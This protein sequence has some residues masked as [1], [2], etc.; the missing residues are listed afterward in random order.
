MLLVVYKVPEERILQLSLYVV[1]LSCNVCSIVFALYFLVARESGVVAFL[2]EHGLDKLSVCKRN[3]SRIEA[4]ENLMV[5]R[6][7]CVQLVP[8]HVTLFANAFF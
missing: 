3:L 7:L 8:Y 5:V 4:V 1:P 2:Q 6:V